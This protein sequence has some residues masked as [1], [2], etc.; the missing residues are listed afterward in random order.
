MVAKK[1]IGDVEPCTIP[2]GCDIPSF[3]RVSFEICDL[4]SE[5][6]SQ[7]VLLLL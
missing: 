3:S 5:S 6:H 7:A 2:D 4:N 1:L